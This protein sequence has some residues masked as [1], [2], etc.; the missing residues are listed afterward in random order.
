[1]NFLE[2]YPKLYFNCL[3]KSENKKE[4][5]KKFSIK[6]KNKN[7]I[8]ELKFKGNLNIFNRKINFKNVSMNKDYEASKEDLK[9]FKESFENILFDNNSLEIFDLNKFRKFLLE[10]S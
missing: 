6:I 9:Y 8:L 4:L 1:M 3:V 2:E 7:E 10:I 5:L